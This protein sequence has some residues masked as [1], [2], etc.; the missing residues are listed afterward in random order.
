MSPPP[1]SAIVE[2]APLAWPAGARVAVWPML[3]I[4]HFVWGRPGTAIQPLL[5]EHP[6]VANWAWRDYG[7]RVAVWR[8]F[9]LFDELEVPLTIC[10]SAE[11]CQHYPRIID[12]IKDRPHWAVLPHGLNN[13]AA[14]HRG[15]SPRA[16]RSLVDR[17]LGTIAKTFGRMPRGFMVPNWSMTEATFEIL[18]EAGVRYTTDWMND[19]Q[20]Y[21]YA[22]RANRLLNVPYNLETNDYTLVLTARLPGPEVS[23]AVID[24]F[25]Q[26]WRDGEPH[27]RSMAIGIHSFI[28]GQPLRVKYVREYLE[29]MKAKGRAWL[30]TSDAIYERMAALSPPG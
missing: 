4:E 23:R 13:N 19:D 9:D 2:R 25:D 22:L 12:A 20:P 15:L 17:S 16:E 7:N 26:L 10:L 18:L 1:Y 3:A 27:G 5:T 14:G 28:S 30:T 8:L 6:E 21:W 24:Y 29:H 11:A